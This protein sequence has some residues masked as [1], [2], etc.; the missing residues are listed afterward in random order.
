M[1]LE[2]GQCQNWNIEAIK[3]LI[4]KQ[5]SFSVQYVVGN[6]AS[7]RKTKEWLCLFLNTTIVV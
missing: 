7:R 3:T 2:C 1:R 6:M 5:V 4:S